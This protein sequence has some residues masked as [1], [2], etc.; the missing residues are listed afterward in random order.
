MFE[1]DIQGARCMKLTSVSTILL[2]PSLPTDKKTCGAL[3]ARQ[4][5]IA[6]FTLPSVEFLKPVGIESADV[7]SRCTC[8]SVVR[9]PM[10]PQE[11]R[12]AVYCGEI[13]SRNSQP[14]RLSHFKKGVWRS[15]KHTCGKTHFGNIKKKL[16][17]ET[18][19]LID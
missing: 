5:S 16:T 13:A 4:A 9:A 11:T 14:V 2:K 6:T 3:A 1:L 18:K 10:A 15:S 17:S 8:D 12:S 19:S 7:S